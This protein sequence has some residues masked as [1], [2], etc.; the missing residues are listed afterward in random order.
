VEN[1][2]KDAKIASLEAQNRTLQEKFAKLEQRLAA[3]EAKRTTR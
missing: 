3:L 1:Q 2:A